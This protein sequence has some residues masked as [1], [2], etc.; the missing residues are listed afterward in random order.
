MHI[1]RDELTPLRAPT[2]APLF[3]EF[4]DY[5]L[6][7]NPPLFSDQGLCIKVKI[8]LAANPSSVS[9]WNRPLLRYLSLYWGESSPLLLPLPLF[10]DKSAPLEWHLPQQMSNYKTKSVLKET[11]PLKKMYILCTD[12]SCHNWFPDFLLVRQNSFTTVYPINCQIKLVWQ[13]GSVHRINIH[14]EATS[15]LKKKLN[16][17]NLLAFHYFKDLMEYIM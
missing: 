14:L 11:W 7:I 2:P 10:R 5:T 9:R 1:C 3:C 8:P 12:P 15:P 4:A 6:I 16:S 13:L 17:W